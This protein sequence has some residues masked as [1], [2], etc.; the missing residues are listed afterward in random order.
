MFAYILNNSIARAVFILAFGSAAF[1]ASADLSAVDVM[2]QTCASFDTNTSAALK[3]YI[4]LDDDVDGIK[5][6]QN[7]LVDI[8]VKRPNK[9]KMI[10]QGDQSAGVFFD[11]NTL[12]AVDYQT[13]HFGQKS[14]TGNLPDLLNLAE[15]LNVPT[16]MLD[17]L[18]K[19][20][21]LAAVSNVATSKVLGNLVLNGE[22]VEHLMFRNEK[23]QIDWQA[24]VKKTETGYALKKVVVTSTYIPEQPQ[25][26]FTIISDNRDVQI[27]DSEF[28][29]AVDSTWTLADFLSDLDNKQP[30]PF[31]ARP[32]ARR[33][34]RRTTRRVVRR[35]YIRALP[36]GCVYGGGLYRCGGVYYRAA[37]E[38]GVT[39]Y[40]VVQN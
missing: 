29:F 34:A 38:D 14:L 33:T 22:I 2:K 36:A 25:Y 32:V 30:A 10:S 11:G 15:D 9:F 40:V 31:Y 16:P 37:I 35:S 7:F 27:D 19:D 12:F 4:S 39:V 23:D 28:N 8:K 18:Q 1:S 20:N 26:Q 6:Q 3:A 21:C 24:W 17:F 13:Q 5:I